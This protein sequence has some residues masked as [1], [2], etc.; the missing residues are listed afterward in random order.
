MAKQGETRYDLFI[1]HAA[2]DRAWVDGYLRHALGVEPAH[3]ITPRDFQLGAPIPA[4]FDSAVT[5]S[6]YTTLVLSPAFLADRWAEF[7]EQLVT[8]TSVEEGR[9]R[10][11]AVTL[12][13]CQPPPRLRFRVGLDCTDWT[14]WDEQ[15][16]RLRDLIGSPE[17]TPEVIPCPYPGMV[18]FRPKERRFFHGREDEIQFLLTNL[19]DHRFL[20]VIGPS[21]SGKSSLVM[22]G[23]LPK[24]DDP[25]TSRTA[26]GNGHDASWRP[27]IRASWPPTGRRAGPTRRDS[28]GLAHHRPPV[29]RLL[30][31]V[32][33]FEEVYSRLRTAPSR[34]GSSP[35]ERITVRCAM[36][37]DC[38][39]AGRLLW[40]FDEQ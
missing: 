6:R 35:A 39:D 29:Q 1:V 9:G 15:A 23:L 33:Q 8:F 26:C 2:A 27:T 34:T 5:S 32:D 4:E 22:A 13:P 38:D 24:L 10:V 12:H 21:G 19:R 20:L 37:G 40:R 36:H 17:P 7:G 11:V 14:Q 18:P 30:L 28:P 16:A 31:V 3:L 25:S